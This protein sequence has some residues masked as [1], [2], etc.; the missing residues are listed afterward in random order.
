[1]HNLNIYPLSEMALT[2]EFAKDI[3]LTAND[4]VIAAFHL[5][6]SSPFPG[7]REAVPAYSSLTIYYNPVEIRRRF[8][9]EQRS[10]SDIVTDL[11]LQILSE[12][13]LETSGEPTIT[14]IPVCYEDE[15]APE[16]LMVADYCG[17]TTVDLVA[18]HTNHLFHVFFTGFVPGFP[19]LGINP[20]PL[21]IPRKKTPLLSV[22]AGSVAI[23]GKQSGIYPFA[24]PGGWNII[25]RTPMKMFDKSAMRPGKLKAGDQVRFISIDKNQYKSLLT[26]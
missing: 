26:L 8:P 19:Y 13:A 4:K 18:L 11:L 1:M 15:Y 17:L 7:Y 9:Y 16:I 23:A 6:K 24:T 3:S 10:V 25:G 14:E 21:E 2:I 12:S 20:E 22:A 5:L